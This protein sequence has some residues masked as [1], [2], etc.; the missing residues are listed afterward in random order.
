MIWYYGRKDLGTGCLKN[1]TYGGDGVSGWE[2]TPKWRE[3][4]KFCMTGRHP[5]IEVRE[6]MSAWQVGKQ[7]SEETKKKISERA[8]GR[9]HYHLHTEESKA[10]ISQKLKGR[11]ITPEWREK[12]RI[13]ALNRRKKTQ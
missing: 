7:L 1:L 12:L 4:Q 13:A 8:Q 9:S 6:K 5:T 3:H 10:K 2:R 11:V